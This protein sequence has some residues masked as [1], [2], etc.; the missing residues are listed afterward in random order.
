MYESPVPIVRAPSPS[1]KQRGSIEPEPSALTTAEVSCRCGAS[2]A[3]SASKTR[4]R[5]ATIR[6]RRADDM[7]KSTVTRRRVVA[8]RTRAHGDAAR[9]C[10]ASFP[11]RPSHIGR[12]KDVRLSRNSGEDTRTRLRV[13][14]NNFAEFVSASSSGRFACVQRQVETRQQPFVPGG[15][16]Y[17]AFSRALIAGRRSGADELIMRRCVVTQRSE[18]RKRHYDVLVGHWL[19]LKRLHL[20]LIDVARSTWQTSS[21]DV[22]IT[23]QLG[24]R[25]GERG[26][27]VVLWLKETPPNTEAIRAIHWLL[28]LEMTQLMPG[29]TPV[30]LDLRREQLHIATRRPYRRDY[31]IQLESDADAY[32]QLWRRLDKA[33]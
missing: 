6:S 14:V 3:P 8:S 1:P 9:C 28:A 30:V 15:D 17:Q 23:P 11:R 16:F 31:E 2:R 26:L 25:D 4:C 29:G 12:G 21:L 24:L 27:V 18:V 20:P 7:T 19:N 10:P 22:S 13:G 33:A 5:P 32:A